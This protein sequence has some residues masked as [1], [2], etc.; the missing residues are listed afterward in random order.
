[1]DEIDRTVMCVLCTITLVGCYFCCVK[2]RI[3]L[4]VWAYPIFSVPLLVFRR[5]LAVAITFFLNSVVSVHNEIRN[6]FLRTSHQIMT[7]ISQWDH[8]VSV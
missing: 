7:L 5:F 4:P 6:M 8:Q 3:M 2:T 1:M